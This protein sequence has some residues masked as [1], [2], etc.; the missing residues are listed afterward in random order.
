MVHTVNCVGVCTGFIPLHMANSCRGAQCASLQV[1][2]RR[3]GKLTWTFVDYRGQIHILLNNLYIHCEWDTLGHVM[4]RYFIP[5]MHAH[6][7][8]SIFNSPLVENFSIETGEILSPSPIDL[9]LQ[10]R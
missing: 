8:F 7:P 5:A 1:V 4:T 3:P 6:F 2:C 10:N 9:L